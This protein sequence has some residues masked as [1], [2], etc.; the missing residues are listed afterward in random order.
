MSP[1]D[2]DVI[3]PQVL[4]AASAVARALN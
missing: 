2:P 4:T 1:L 3:G